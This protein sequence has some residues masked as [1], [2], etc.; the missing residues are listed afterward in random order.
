[1]EYNH[2][3]RIGKAPTPDWKKELYEHIDVG[4]QKGSLDHIRKFAKKMHDLKDHNKKL[5]KE[6]RLK[7]E[8][9]E[10]QASVIR[11]LRMKHRDWEDV[12]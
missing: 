1:M 4:I 8:L 2:N 6:N 11:D 9:I 3:K 10:S 7:D 5:S 12:A